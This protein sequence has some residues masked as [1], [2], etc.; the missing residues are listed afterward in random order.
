MVHE[1][2][3][4]G[5]EQKYWEIMKIPH[6]EFTREFLK[7][8]QS[9]SV[10]ANNAIY[11]Y[12]R[13]GSGP[14]VVLVHGYNNN[15]GIM[16]AI[17]EDLLEQG[18]RVVL[19]DAPAHGEAVGARTNPLE[20][21]DLIRKISSQLGEIH[22]VVGYSLGTMWTLAAWGDDFRPKTLVSIASPSDFRFSV[23]KF[24]EMQ[25]A[26]EA[27]AEELSIQ[28]EK[29]FGKTVWADLSP[30]ELVKNLEVP[31]LIIHGANDD[32]VPPDHAE[33]LQAS[34]GDARVEV[35]DGLG[36]FDIPGS[37]KTRKLV[38]TYLREF[39]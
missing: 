35:L 23:R 18:F 12:Y 37:L 38:T 9:C 31:G 16:V 8:C 4:V 32:F 6:D 3:M 10:R 29:R 24:V 36:H 27:A 25:Q 17:A 21:R 26:G 20:V 22:A 34:W 39:Q 19:F 30:S 13:R 33:Q 2:E 5:I 28:L 7:Q 15:L 11:K 14:T 1:E